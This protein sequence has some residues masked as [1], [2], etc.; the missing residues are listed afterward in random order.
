MLLKAAG[1]LA[2]L[3]AA[4]AITFTVAWNAGVERG[5]DNG[6][7]YMSEHVVCKLDTEGQDILTKCQLYFGH[8]VK[9]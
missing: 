4:I 1:R 7:A 3:V 5:Q 8:V 2:F 6:R 9:R